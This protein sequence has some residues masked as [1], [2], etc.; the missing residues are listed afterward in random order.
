MNQFRFHY[1][2]PVRY[3]DLD[4]QWHVNNTRFLTFAEQA[5]FAFLMELGL[6]D[7]KSFWDLPLIVGDIHCR[8]L[9]PI[10]PG[11][12][13][14]VS[15][16]VTKIGNK[17]LVMESHIT[18]ETG[19]PLHA[20]IETTMVAYDYH[21]KSAVPVSDELRAKFEAFEGKSFPKG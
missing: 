6:F 21:T 1:P 15:M 2:I 11:V 17:S 13:V 19:A 5:R 7:G 16:G 14:T 4:P 10:N 9:V 18:G 20:V 12:T 8:Y 3:G